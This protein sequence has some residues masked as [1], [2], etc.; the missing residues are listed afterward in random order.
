MD[1][2]HCHRGRRRLWPTLQLLDFPQDY[3]KFNI[4]DAPEACV[5]QAG[6]GHQKY[7]FINI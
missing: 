6:M 1:H 2:G 7:K 5:H 4:F 3:D